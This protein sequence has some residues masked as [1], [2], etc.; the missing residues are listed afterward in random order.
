MET[1]SNSKKKNVKKVGPFDT[2]EEA[3][4][5]KNAELMKAFKDVDLTKFAQR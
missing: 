2:L 4:K 1:L 5:F 3:V